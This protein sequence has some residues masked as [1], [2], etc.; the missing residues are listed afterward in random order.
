M[1]TRLR[2]KRRPSF[3]RTTYEFG[4]WH[5][6]EITPGIHL[7][8]RFFVMWTRTAWPT[9]KKDDLTSG[10]RALLNAAVDCCRCKSCLTTSGFTVRGC[11]AGGENGSVPRKFRPCK[12]TAGDGKDPPIGVER[13]DANASHKVRPS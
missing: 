4:C 6:A 5:T 9:L 12:R 1:A 3:V 7:L 2:R 13:M 11:R 10:E 8:D